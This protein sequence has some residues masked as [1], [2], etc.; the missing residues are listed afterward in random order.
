MDTRDHEAMT[1]IIAT[2][3]G[4]GH[5]EHVELAWTYLQMYPPSRAAEAMVAAIR[6]LSHEHGAERKFHETITRAWLHCVAVH[7]QRWGAT[8]FDTFLGRNPEL[9]DRTLLGHF[10]SPE[11]IASDDARAAWS[12]P[13]LRQLP[14]LV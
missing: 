11:L 7:A 5:R 12:D 3:G 6:R 2:R 10:Y 13:D 1:R 4:F 14:A 9:L 8:D